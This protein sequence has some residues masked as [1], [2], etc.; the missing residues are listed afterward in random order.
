[1]KAR[2]IAL[3]VLL[4]AVVGIAAWILVTPLTTRHEKGQRVADTKATGPASRDDSV[5]ET[6][7]MAEI[8]LGQP[9]PSPKDVEPTGPE[10]GVRSPQ[11]AGDR[12]LLSKHLFE[13]PQPQ[14]F[15]AVSQNS[16]TKSQK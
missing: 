1:M 14:K 9:E 7:K 4:A 10:V 13:A 3:A 8:L 2:R 11:M 12:V 5:I 16:N 6:G 15:E